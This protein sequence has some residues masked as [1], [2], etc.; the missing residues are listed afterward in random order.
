MNRVSMGSALALA[1]F[2]IAVR[3]GHSFTRCL[4]FVNFG[5]FLVRP[6]V[7]VIWY[8]PAPVWMERRP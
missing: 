7:E 1:V 5:L 3:G 2:L 4:V 8:S 6:I